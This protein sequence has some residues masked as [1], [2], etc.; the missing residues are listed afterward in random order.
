M[1]ENAQATTA[2]ILLILFLLLSFP[3]GVLT[4]IGWCAWLI[5]KSGKG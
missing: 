5:A 3:L 1:S 4:V 2:G